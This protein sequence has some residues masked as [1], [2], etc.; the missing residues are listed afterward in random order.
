MILYRQPDG[1]K[2]GCQRKTYLYVIGDTK[3]GP[4]K[5][6]ISRSVGRETHWRREADRIYEFRFNTGEA[7][8]R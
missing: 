4:V 7:L 8:T 2:H 1:A 5:V 3:G 6:G